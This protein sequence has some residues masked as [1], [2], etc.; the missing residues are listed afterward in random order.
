MGPVQQDQFN[1]IKLSNKSEEECMVNHDCW[2]MEM[3]SGNAWNK[4]HENMDSLQHFTT[5]YESSISHQ[6]GAFFSQALSNCSLD[7][8][9]VSAM[10][11]A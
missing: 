5:T 4:T 10:S 11:S 6:S 8:R 7:T 2:K 3:A 9:A 1:S